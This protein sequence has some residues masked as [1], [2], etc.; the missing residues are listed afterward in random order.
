MYMYGCVA[1]FRMDY[2][3]RLGELGCFTDD[4]S[5]GFLVCHGCWS[6]KR[7]K[8]FKK[9]YNYSCYHYGLLNPK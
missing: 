1:K 5:S 8:I 2:I 4:P 3:A 7:I 6:N 9:G